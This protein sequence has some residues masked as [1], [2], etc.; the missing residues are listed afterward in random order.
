VRVKNVLEQ[1]TGT[2]E[3]DEPSNKNGLQEVNP[4]GKMTGR[5]PQ[6]PKFNSSKESYVYYDKRSTQRGVY[7]RDKFYYRSDP[8][9]TRF[10]LDNFTNAGLNFAGTLVSGRHLPRHQGTPRPATRLC[11]RVRACHG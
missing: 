9:Q 2:L 1:V 8:F 5:Y 6:L 3:I 11:A 10:S 4:D 7:V